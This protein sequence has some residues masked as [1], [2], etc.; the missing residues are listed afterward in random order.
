MS[1]KYFSAPGFK[2][3]Q[4]HDLEGGEPLY[5]GIGATEQVLRMGYVGCSGL[6]LTTLSVEYGFRFHLNRLM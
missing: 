1:T 5:P 4:Y 2:P 6:R 3:A